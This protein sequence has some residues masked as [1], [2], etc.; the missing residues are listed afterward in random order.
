MQH[1]PAKIHADMLDAS[2]RILR[3]TN[4]ITFTDYLGNEIIQLAVERL[5]EMLGEA[6]GRLVK[7]APHLANKIDHHRR[8]ID[9]RNFLSHGYDLVDP[10]IV[11]DA[12]AFH[13]PLVQTQVSKLLLSLGEV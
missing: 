9:F 7:T 11:W 12:I 3:L 2:S 10:R 5:F 1:N 4:G 8:I 13:L 6:L